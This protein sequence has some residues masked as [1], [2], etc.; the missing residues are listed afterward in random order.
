MLQGV[1]EAIPTL[2]AQRGHFTRILYHK[3]SVTMTTL[4]AQEYCEIITLLFLAI[5][6]SL[7]Q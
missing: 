6:Q 4:L 5:T 7:L 3:C 1:A 2:F